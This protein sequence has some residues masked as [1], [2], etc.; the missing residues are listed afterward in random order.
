MTSQNLTLT[1][2]SGLYELRRPRS[3]GDGSAMSFDLSGHDIEQAVRSAVSR[4]GMQ[5]W[6]LLQELGAFGPSLISAPELMVSTFMEAL[7][8]GRLVLARDGGSRTDDT[9]PLWLAYDAFIAQVGREFMVG[10]R[11]HRLASR[12]YAD[13]LRREAN[14]DVVPAPEAAALIL[15]LGQSAGAGPGRTAAAPLAKSMVDMRSPSGAA[16]FMLLRAPASQAE[17]IVSREE[18]ITP[19][20]LKKL[21][22]KDWV[23]IHLVDE[24]GNPWVGAYELSLP[25]GEVR[26]G[27]VAED[28]LLRVDNIL[29]GMCELVLPELDG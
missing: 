7:K 16:G 21:A 11:A 4:N 2:L 9:D 17:R 10:M 18:A 1:T 27:T 12:E 5:A 15:R 26:K 8:W 22:A 23:E 3:L 14:Y 20:K 6:A 19:A 24:E 13:E 29:S 25:G 28:G